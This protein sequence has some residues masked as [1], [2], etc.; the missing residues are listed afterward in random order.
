MCLKQK[1]PLHIKDNTPKMH[2]KSQIYT[3]VNT[4]AYTNSNT[5]TQFIPCPPPLIPL[6]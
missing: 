5:N 3:N 6:N 1:I 2:T 4:Y